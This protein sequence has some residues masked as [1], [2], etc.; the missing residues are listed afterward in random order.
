MNSSENDIPWYVVHAQTQKE[1]MAAAV[2]QSRLDM[3]VY[4]PEVLQTRRGKRQR[5]PLFPGYFFVQAPASG[6]PTSLINSSPG[7]IRVVSFDWIPQPLNPQIVFALQES[8]EQVNEQG[9]LPQH[10]FHPGDTVR[11]QSGPLAGLEAVFLGPL[12][13]A[14]RVE[15]LLHFLGS[16]R[17]VQMEPANLER[18]ANPIEVIVRKR[19]SRGV[20][21]PIQQL[22]SR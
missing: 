9:G 10:S 20:G 15:I 11:V 13:P 1:L 4:L 14:A 8:V 7:I 16:Q 6:L 17:K 3:T 18:V 22:E 19:R 2:L 5:A 12:K 21:R